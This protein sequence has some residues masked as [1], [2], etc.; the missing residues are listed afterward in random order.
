MQ[1]LKTFLTQ[2]KPGTLM[3]HYS[4]PCIIS[5]L[6][7]ALYNI[8]DQI[9][10]ANA[11]YL[12][13]YGN[14]AN[15]V[16]Y[17]L[18]VAA[19]SVAVLIGDGVC[20][21]SSIASGAGRTDDTHH[22]VG[23]GIVMCIVS[24]LVITALYLVFADQIITLFGGAVSQRTLEL[25]Q[26]YF[27]WI[28][29]GIPFYMLG[30]AANPIIR[31]DGSPRFAMF[32]TLI[33]CVVNIILD[34]IFIFPLGMGMKGAAIATVIGQILTA[35]V[36]L[37]YLKDMRT[38]HLRKESFHLIPRIMRQTLYLGM[39]SFLS[40][41]SIVCSM[42]VMQNMVMRYGAMDP[43]FSQ[44]EYAQ[45][46]MAVLGIV[47]KVFQIVISV[48]VG[49]AAGMIPVLG[50]NIGAALKERAAKMFK[51]VLK[52][53]LILGIAALLVVELLPRQ[54]IGIFG[55]A[56]EAEIYTEFAIKSFR[57][58]LM[59]IPLATVNKGTFISMQAIGKA[60]ESTLLSLF[61]EI[62]LG[63]GLATLLP[64]FFGLDG[65]LY[66]MPASDFFA[67]LV[68]AHLILTTLRE[69]NSD[70]VTDLAQA[71]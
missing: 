70:E 49:I 52:S 57:L 66:S 1:D 60:K 51:L 59:L 36:S 28:T 9:F 6:V 44:P 69:L 34:P 47:M 17:P 33:G 23:N 19:L 22:A 53:E 38:M 40:Q 26:E 21:F 27:F 4:L 32:A 45:I 25:S 2:E 31:S 3:R 7:A 62:V 12:G 5:L 29:L 46:P 71:K 50:F 16:V 42:A 58:Y 18:T 37:W 56:N 8:V 63:C 35:V 39:T 55:A 65:V 48:S 30:Q 43:T 67:F 64:V 41:I 20:A 10:I 13:S 68:A 11:S 54:L 15:T 14:S 61:R 24:S